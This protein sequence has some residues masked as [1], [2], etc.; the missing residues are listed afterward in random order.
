[1]DPFCD[2]NVFLLKGVLVILSI[3][4]GAPGLKRVFG[5]VELRLME[6]GVLRTRRNRG[7]SFVVRVGGVKRGGGRK[8]RG[9]REKISASQNLRHWERHSRHSKK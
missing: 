5:R 7:G 2:S 1:M 8:I 3:S 6:Y 4:A 9:R